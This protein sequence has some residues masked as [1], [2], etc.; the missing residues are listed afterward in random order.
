MNELPLRAASATVES[1]TR[2]ESSPPGRRRGTNRAKESP[3]RTA[4]AN[5][6]AA[7]PLPMATWES[8]PTGFW[9][10]RTTANVALS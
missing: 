6:V 5:S 9:I 4:R 8:V 3:D 10:A 2:W 7:P 1:N